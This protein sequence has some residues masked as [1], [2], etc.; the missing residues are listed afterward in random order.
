MRWP[1]VKTNNEK[2]LFSIVFYDK[3]SP[4]NPTGLQSDDFEIDVYLMV[5]G[6]FESD[7]QKLKY[8]RYLQDKLN[9]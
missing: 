4:N 8:C 2:G 5:S 9:Q 7:D 3:E 6:D 1:R